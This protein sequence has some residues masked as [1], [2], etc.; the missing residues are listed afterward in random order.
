VDADGAVLSDGGGPIKDTISVAALGLQ[1]IDFIYI[2]RAQAEASGAAEL[3]TR[4]RHRFATTRGLADDVIV[5]IEFADAGG[6]AGA[7]SFAEVL[8][9]VDRL[10]KLLGTARG[11]DSR[12]FQ[13]IS[14]D[15]P[16]SPDNPG[17]IDVAEL[18]GRV[19]LR[20]AAVRGLFPPLGAA[21]D[22]ARTSTASADIDA[23]RAA[24]INV[25]GSGFSYAMPRSTSGAAA[26]QRDAL[27]A[28]ADALV[29]RAAALDLTTTRQ[30][31]DAA[32]ATGAESVL[33]L[34][35][36]VV[37]TWM[38]SDMLLLPRF[39]Y[40]DVAAVQQADAARDGLLANARAAGSPLPLEEWLHGAACVRPLVHD[41]EMLRAMA[42]AAR[43]DPLALSAIQLPFRTGDSWLGAEYPPAMQ[44]L[45]DTVS[46][47]QHL[48]QGFTPA[49]AQCGLMVDEWTE[50][51]PTREGVTGLTFNFNAPNSAP[52]QA[53]LLAVTPNETGHWSWDDLVD[54]V[55]DTFRRAELRAV[56]PDALGELSGIGTLLP[57]IVAEFSTSAASVSLDYS[58]VM[59][60]IRGPVLAMA[61]SVAPG[62]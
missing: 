13:S 31:A 39:E 55:L 50:S 11:L 18:L 38:G 60:E 54:A 10:R 32:A 59:A 25:A 57:A 37:K 1:P 40:G 15:T 7:R 30:L 48:P 26:A 12:H 62:G 43:T 22:A 42:D 4:I 17:R 5:R 51:V 28:Q 3:E 52:P 44:V 61:G 36:V 41:F 2:V 33:S 24:L 23:L 9:L 20:I 21:T 49:A 46:V 34:L 19:N 14:K 56:E 8:P 47:V 27:V 16:A 53:V 45:H 58:M 35:S 29:A 6:G